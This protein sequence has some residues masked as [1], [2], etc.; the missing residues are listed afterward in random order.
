MA[1]WQLIALDMD[2]TSLDLG[3]DISPEN[4]RAIRQAIAAGVQVTFATG[5]RY[6][7]L[8]Q[9]LARELGMTAPVVTV[10]GGEVWTP[11][12]ELVMR[13]AHRPEDIRWLY[14]LAVS[15]GAHC[16]AT[17]PEG[18]LSDDPLPDD[19]EDRIWLKFG[20]YTEDGAA[21]ASL[22]R[23]LEQAERFELSNS[24]P[25]NIEVNPKG[26]TKAAGL[27]TV[28][29]RLAI[30]PDQ[31]VAVGDSLNDVP[32]IRWAGLGVAMGNAQPAVKAEADW[33][34]DGCEAHGVAR[35]IERILAERSGGPERHPGR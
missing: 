9:D 17:T 34:A 12:G 23:A 15:H 14:Q 8:V 28:C 21:L 11:G 24:N 13:R 19:L 10:N 18:I 35:V 29:E 1:D 31:V 25:F 30:R 3:L 6:G 33:I 16:W 22:W 5:R 32:M 26:V 7:G 20:F 2:G 27:A 4:R